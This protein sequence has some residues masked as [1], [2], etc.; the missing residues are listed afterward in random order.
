MG[1]QSPRQEEPD[2]SPQAGLGRPLAGAEEQRDPER[3]KNERLEF[4]RATHGQVL[5][6][7]DLHLFQNHICVC[8]SRPVAASSMISADIVASQSEAI[9]LD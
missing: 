7:L 6:V 1:R 5:H 9:C 4:T 3:N 8:D 2:Y